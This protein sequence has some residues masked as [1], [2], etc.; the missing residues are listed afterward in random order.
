LLAWTPVFVV[1]TPVVVAWTPLLVDVVAEVFPRAAGLPGAVVAEPPFIAPLFVVAA[2]FVLA[3]EAAGAF[4]V[5]AWLPAAE[6]G[7][8][9][10][11]FVPGDALAFPGVGVAVGLFAAAGWPAGVELLAPVFCAVA[12]AAVAAASARI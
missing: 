12:I 6:L 4:L 3:V 5:V 11:R 10:V 1:G 8:L 9:E 2:L 7:V